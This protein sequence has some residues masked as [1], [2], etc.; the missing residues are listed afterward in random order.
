MVEAMNEAY[1]AIDRDGIVLDWNRA[2]RADCSAS[3]PRGGD[4][5][6][7]DGADHPARGP[8]RLR[9]PD[10]PL[11]RPGQA[12]RQPLDLRAERTAVAP[13][14]PPV[15]RSSSRR[16]PSSTRTRSCSTPS[17]T[18][19]AT[20]SGPSRARPAR[21]RR[22]GARRRRAASWPAAPIPSEAREAICRAR[23]D[24]RRAP[25]SRCC[26]SPSPAGAACGP[27]AS[28]GTEVRRR[29]LPFVG[30]LRA[31][32]GRSPPR[33]ALRRRRRGDP[34]VVQSIFAGLDA[35]LAPTGCRS[36]RGQRAA[37][38]DRRRLG[39][40]ASRSSSERLERVMGLVAAEAA[41]A[42]ERAALLERLARMART[43]DLTG[44][45]NRRAW[46][47]ELVRELARA[48]RDGEAA[49]RR[50]G[51]PRPLQGLQRPP[52]PPGRRPAAQGGR[53]RLALGTARDRSARPLR[54]RGVRDRAAR[55]A[56][57]RTP[58]PGRAAARGDPGRRVLLGRDRRLGRR[59]S[60][61]RSCSAA[62]TRPSTRRSRRAATEPSLA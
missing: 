27:T 9:R 6:A 25:R 43:D 59:A 44:L 30:P 3:A 57:P 20:A 13:R 11:P 46:D 19:S 22:R 18:T 23:D 4:R 10:R 47:Q 53:R 48:G 58:A 49:D 39:R 54:R 21:D 24:G 61:P 28:V 52:R 15:H 8:R 37:R 14:R 51:R 62:P 16:R 56:S 41:V 32:C 33:A 55:A 26:S 34:A 5:P 1:V 40:A 36:A 29:L 31:R 35:R 12:A 7:D 50:D 17:C 38:R 42:I 2:R 45:P 60:R